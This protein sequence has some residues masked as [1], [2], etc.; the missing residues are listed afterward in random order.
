MSC[1]WKE[2]GHE[3]HGLAR[4]MAQQWNH[5]A[6]GVAIRKKMSQPWMPSAFR[7]IRPSRPPCAT[8]RFLQGEQVL[9]EERRFLAGIGF[10]GPLPMRVVGP[11]GGVGEGGHEH[12]V[13]ATNH[14]AAH[15]VK[16]QVGEED[17]GDVLWANPASRRLIQ[18]V[19][20]M[21]VVVLKNFSDCL[22]PM[23]QSIKINR[24]SIS[25][26]SERIAQVEVL[27]IGG[28]VRDQSCCGTTPNIAPPS[29]LKSRCESCAIA[30][31]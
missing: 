16:V 19:F 13:A 5:L 9:G 11:V 25:T 12:A 28:L 26:R 2:V 14:A 15:M 18:R 30:W 8:G 6:L 27:G 4:G 22:S 10:Q 21:Q 31:G 24:E 20:A 17:V 7:V 23:P 3:G 29:N 1:A